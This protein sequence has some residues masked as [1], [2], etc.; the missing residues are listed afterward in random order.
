M[1]SDWEG[2]KKRED[3]D[4][5]EGWTEMNEKGSMAGIDELLAI[6]WTGDVPKRNVSEI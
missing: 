1:R 5:I 4:R 3:L 2:K 6:G